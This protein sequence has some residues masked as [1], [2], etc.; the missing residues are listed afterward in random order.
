M[1]RFKASIV[2]LALVVGCSTTARQEQAV[3]EEGYH[4][5]ESWPADGPNRAT[6]KAQ[7][8]ADAKPFVTAS[9]SPAPSPAAPK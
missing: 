6:A 8:L 4:L 3:I 7:F 9:P 2:A 1:A 5:V